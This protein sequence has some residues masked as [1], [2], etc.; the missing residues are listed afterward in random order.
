M[1]RFIRIDVLISCRHRLQEKY[2]IYVSFQMLTW[3]VD[4]SVLAVP[5]KAST[6]VIPEDGVTTL[7]RRRGAFKQPKVHL[8]RNH[9]FSATFFAQPT[10]CSVC[11]DFLW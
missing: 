11:K 10:F 6:K 4:L 5:G 8:M 1:L 7:N 9:E 3:G 2:L